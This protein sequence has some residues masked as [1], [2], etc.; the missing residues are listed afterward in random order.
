MW[1]RTNIGGRLINL[2]KV[3]I[4]MLSGNQISFNIPYEITDSYE[5]EL[6]AEHAFN[7]LQL[8]LLGEPIKLKK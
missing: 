1:Y 8:L 2:N 4:I 3:Q 6:E 5:S 7:G